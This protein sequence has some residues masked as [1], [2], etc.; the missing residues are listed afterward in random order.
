[1][2]SV[3]WAGW[4]VPLY[5]S[6]VCRGAL[7]FLIKIFLLIKKKKKNLVDEKAPKNFNI[8]RLAHPS[9]LIANLLYSLSAHCILEETI[10]IDAKHIFPILVC[11]INCLHQEQKRHPSC[12]E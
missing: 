3:L 12:L 8:Q 7:R 4:V 5:T 2:D 9:N 1:M 6:S 10:K 11:Y